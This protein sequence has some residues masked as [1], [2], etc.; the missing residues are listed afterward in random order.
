L[1]RQGERLLTFTFT[2]RFVDEVFIC[3]HFRSMSG[4]SEVLCMI[5][6]GIIQHDFDLDGKIY[7]DAI[8]QAAPDRVTY[9]K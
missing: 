2:V 6:N 5:D 9:G 4:L 3:R 8:R 1:F 7:L